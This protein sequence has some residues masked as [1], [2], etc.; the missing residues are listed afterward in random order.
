M[1][2][3]ANY[4]HTIRAKANSRP[5]LLTAVDDGRRKRADSVSRIEENVAAFIWTTRMSAG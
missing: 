1:L 5:P 3:I 2:D 4:G